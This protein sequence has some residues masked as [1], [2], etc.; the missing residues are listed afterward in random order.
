MTFE[1]L[2][3]K[4]EKM[5]PAKRQRRAEVFSGREVTYE[6]LL[7]EIKAMSLERRQEEGPNWWSE[8]DLD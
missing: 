8:I 6:K 2:E 3:K 1:D 4:I 5:T 7:E